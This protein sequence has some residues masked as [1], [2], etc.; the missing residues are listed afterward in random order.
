MVLW[1]DADGIY[2][3]DGQKPRK[4][5]LPVD[6]YF[7]PEYSTAIST[8]YLGDMQSFLD[9]YNGEYHLLC[10]ENGLELVYN[11]I[12]GEWYPPWSRSIGLQC[13]L[14][15]KGDDKRHYVYGGSATG[16]VVELETDTT[17]KNAS[18]A[19]VAIEHYVTTRAIGAHEQV[20]DVYDFKLGKIFPS[21]KAQSAGD[22]TV[23]LYPDTVSAGTSLG[24]V[25]LIRSGYETTT[26]PADRVDTRMGNF[27]VKF[28]SSTADV[29]ME[30]YAFLYELDIYG[31]LSN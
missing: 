16:F 28:S 20:S 23:T 9:R 10:H 15:L 4:V 13:A 7:N 12:A 31:E 1:Q 18:N 29:E 6:H 11:Y 22:V 25:S 2:V 24:T 17:D 19:D 26:P 14:E 21:F 3:L 8:A 5:S 30:L 27:C